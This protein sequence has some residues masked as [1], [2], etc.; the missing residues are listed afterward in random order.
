MRKLSLRVH[1]LFSSLHLLRK[2]TVTCT[3]DVYTHVSTHTHTQRSEEACDARDIEWSMSKGWGRCRAQGL[4]RV[5]DRREE[6]SEDDVRQ[7]VEEVY[8]KT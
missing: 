4:Q 7:R 5:G 3:L 6:A 2:E 8:I 1:S